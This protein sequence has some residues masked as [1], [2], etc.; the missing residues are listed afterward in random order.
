VPQ[1]DAV[2]VV[3]DGIIHQPILPPPPAAWLGCARPRLRHPPGHFMENPD[4]TA[5]DRYAKTA[6]ITKTVHCVAVC[7]I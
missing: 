7:V 4:S 1:I 2:D 5:I 3:A 6:A